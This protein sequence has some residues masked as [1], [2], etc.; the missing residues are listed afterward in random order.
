M[1]KEAKAF[2]NLL[3]AGLGSDKRF[4]AG[5]PSRKKRSEKNAINISTNKTSILA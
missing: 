5:K 3:Q 2:I 1:R 4:E